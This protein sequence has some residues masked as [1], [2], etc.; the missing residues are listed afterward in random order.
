LSRCF[1]AGIEANQRE[2]RELAPSRRVGLMA[3]LGRP[4]AE[5]VWLTASRDIGSCFVVDHQ[6]VSLTTIYG[7][8]M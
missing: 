7:H 6:E 3:R 5:K 4:R 2:R 8:E 1:L